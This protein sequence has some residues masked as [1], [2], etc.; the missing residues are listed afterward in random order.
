MTVESSK[1]SDLTLMRT[2]QGLQ[3][4]RPKSQR[5]RMILLARLT[6]HILDDDDDDDD[7]AAADDDDDYCYYYYYDG[8]DN[9]EEEEEK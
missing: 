5:Q 8:D 4:S 6:V 2:S 7:D 1:D 3:Y 9:I